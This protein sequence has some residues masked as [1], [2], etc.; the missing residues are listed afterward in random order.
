MLW[1]TAAVDHFVLPESSQSD[2]LV[3]SLFLFGLSR[4]ELLRGCRAWT[5]PCCCM[6]VSRRVGIQAR[7]NPFQRRTGV[8]PGYSARLTAQRSREDVFGA[9]FVILKPTW[10]A[11]GRL[12]ERCF[13]YLR[14]KRNRNQTKQNCVHQHDDGTD[15]TGHSGPV[16]LR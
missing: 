13:F 4:V 1:R 15:Q 9:D 5:G 8:P 6:R 16:L 7:L 12:L 11:G 10:I 2:V 14:L 3:R